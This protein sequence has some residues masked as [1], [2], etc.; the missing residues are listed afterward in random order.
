VNVIGPC[1]NERPGCLV[2]GP[3]YHTRNAEIGT[4]RFE[5]E[6]TARFASLLR[7]A[8]NL[9]D[10]VAALIADRLAL[11]SALLRAEQ[12]AAAARAEAAQMA[13]CLQERLDAE[14]QHHTYLS[15]LA[16]LQAASNAR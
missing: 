12:D 16:G 9:G 13:Q 15:D 14:R 4:T 5:D 3:H 8:S 2:S 11:R 1:I 10:Q 6:V 7:T